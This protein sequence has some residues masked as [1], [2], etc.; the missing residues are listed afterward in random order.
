MRSTSNLFTDYEQWKVTKV[1]SETNI[2]PFDI[3]LG[4]KIVSDHPAGNG[5]VGL[6][7]S[8]IGKDS[9]ASILDVI[10]DTVEIILFDMKPHLNLFNFR[11]LENDWM[12]FEKVYIG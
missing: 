4:A 3:T 7:Y 1:T 5:N 2:F 10:F 12:I 6:F 9:V 11:G 8:G